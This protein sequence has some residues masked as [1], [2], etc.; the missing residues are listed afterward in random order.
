[1]ELVLDP[2][3]ILAIIVLRM[4]SVTHGVHVPAAKDMAHLTVVFLWV[5]AIIDTIAAS[6]QRTMIVANVCS[7][8]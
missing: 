1:M 7:M 8:Q 6:D 4:H 2:K 3:L 5:R